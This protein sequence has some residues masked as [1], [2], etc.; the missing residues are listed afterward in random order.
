[1]DRLPEGIAMN[2]LCSLHNLLGIAIVAAA[3]FSANNANA[4][5]YAQPCTY[6]WVAV[7]ES[8]RVPYT[9]CVTY[10]HSDGNTYQVHETRYR[11]VQSYAKKRVLV[12][13]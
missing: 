8:H 4:C 2:V 10:Y 5:D 3:L 1:M 6:K 13:E 12:C 7:A 11:T 9:V